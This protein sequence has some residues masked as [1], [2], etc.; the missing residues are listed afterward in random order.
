MDLVNLMI[1]AKPEVQNL[2]W[3]LLR[4]S[5]FNHLAS[6]SY[7]V[8][9]A[10]LLWDIRGTGMISHL[11]QLLK[12]GWVHIGPEGTCKTKTGQIL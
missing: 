10:S 11:M 9:N 5:R 3:V 8:V 4:H 12:M 1:T 6:S 2:S 7:K